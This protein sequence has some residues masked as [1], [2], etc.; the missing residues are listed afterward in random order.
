MYHTL[1]PFFY[2]SAHEYTESNSK[3]AM[4]VE[5]NNPHLVKRVAGVK[6]R[7]ARGEATVPFLMKDEKM[8]NPFLRVDK[9]SE[10]RANVGVSSSDPDSVAFG[11]LRKAKDN[12]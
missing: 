1:T 4:H 2:D 5:P 6:E 7:R 8:T 11:K 10:I 12:F 9:S 3:F